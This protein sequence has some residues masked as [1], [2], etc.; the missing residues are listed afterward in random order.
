MEI[1]LT[2]IFQE[3]VIDKVFCPLV[4]SVRMIDDDKTTSQPCGLSKLRQ[5][6]NS[7]GLFKVN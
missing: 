6:P 7:S 5:N 4:R 1:L 2:K 3:N